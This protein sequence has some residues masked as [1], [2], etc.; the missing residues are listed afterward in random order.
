M[1]ILPLVFG[2][3]FNSASAFTAVY[4]R[5]WGNRIG[6]LVSLV[7]RNVLGIPLWVLGLMLATQTPSLLLFTT[8]PV[9]TT[10]GWVL[11]TAG[12]AVILWALPVLGRRAAVPAIGDMLAVG[13]PYAYIRHPIYTGTSLE[14]AGIF[15]LHATRATLLA[16]FLGICWL[17]IQAKLEELDLLERI[18]SYREYMYRVP[19]FVP[20]L[21]RGRSS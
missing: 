2:F 6:K 9:I 10:L 21:H 20:H 8:I 12:G 19:R 15:L 7:L 1:Y 3:A 16:F 17:F 5:R 14:F 13:G 18:P 4:S 11:I